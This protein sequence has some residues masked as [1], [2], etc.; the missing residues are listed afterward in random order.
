L[1]GD[2]LAGEVLELADEIALPALLVDPRLVVVRAQV[3]EVG[4]GVR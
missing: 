4:G 1:E 2:A 3:V